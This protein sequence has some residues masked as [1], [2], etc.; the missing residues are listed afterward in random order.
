MAG[1]SP[2]RDPRG[3]FRRNAILLT[4][5]VLALLSVL[6]GFELALRRD[7]AL[8]AS[9]QRALDLAHIL[10]RYVREAFAAQDAALRQLAASNARIGGPRAPEREWQPLLAAARAGIGTVGGIS[11]V[12]RDGVICHATLPTMVG[13][14]RR[15]GY[16]FGVLSSDAGAGLVAS[17]PS[18][19]RAVFGGGL[20]IPLGRR[21]EDA[22]G[23]FDGMVIATLRPDS[24]RA[25]FHTIDVGAEGMVSLLHAHGVVLLREPSMRAAIGDDAA[26][27]PL[28]AFGLAHG[29]GTL[30]T[31]ETPAQPAMRNGVVAMREQ[32]LV[33]AVSL[34]EREVLAWV[35]RDG[36]V[37]AVILGFLTLVA[38]AS[39]LAAFRLQDRRVAMQLAAQR[40]QHL[41][42]LGRLT[43]GVAHDF[44]NLLAVILG[45]ASLVRIDPRSPTFTEDK[46]A[47]DEIRA[48]ATRASDLTKQLLAF[49]RRQPLQPRRIAVSDVLR[50]MEPLLQ[51]TV[52]EDVVLRL[53]LRDAGATKIDPVQFDTAILN[54][55]VNARHAMP[56][57]GL[58]VIES[59]RLHLDEHYARA[60]PDAR[61]G[62][63]SYVSVA[64]TGTGIPA[65][66]LPHVFEP[67]FTTRP[68]NEG[69]GLGLAMVYGFVRQSGGHAR[70]Y[71]EV[72]QGTTVKLYFPL[73]T[74]DATEEHPIRATDA[75][76]G[77]GEVILLAEDDRA[78]RAGATRMLESLGYHVV[79]AADG[80]E[81][82]AR[83]HAEPRI[84]LLF[85]DVVLP[86]PF[87][88]LE[89]AAELRT[90]R[91]ELPALFTSGYSLDIIQHRTAATS[92]HLLSKPYDHTALAHAV[93]SALERSNPV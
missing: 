43:G 79:A 50:Q 67:F 76:R 63:F 60:N 69:T 71:S 68:A 46:E 44:N 55:V 41:E 30:R 89:L 42:V 17:T 21:L 28:L 29:A 31:A 82:M 11:V 65:D 22:R 51:R 53:N 7:R 40:S 58:L 38:A 48:A 92:L 45:Y 2:R 26:A 73:T 59:G 3:A 93:R 13:E 84:D 81:A 87:S 80:P 6:R 4:V 1:G 49:A 14:S 27:D 66:V 18:P 10:A 37:S 12:D 35:D 86:G 70:V 9:D 15:A 36:R 8:Q 61:A 91:P 74:D 32:S 75:P 39:L 34:S 24:L 88:G 62:D 47:I 90:R 52:G 56:R 5:A 25:F 77:H 54:L 33:V 85:T 19:V 23:A 72:G 83:A 78:L 16:L 57:G 20:M 64:D